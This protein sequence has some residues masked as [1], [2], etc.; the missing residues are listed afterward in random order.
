MCIWREPGG[1]AAIHCSPQQAGRLRA[2]RENHVAGTEE[3]SSI[4]LK[5]E[6]QLYLVFLGVYLILWL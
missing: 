3:C 5:R 2:L 4:E 6:E 1:A